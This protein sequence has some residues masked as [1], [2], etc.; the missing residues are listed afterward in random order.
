MPHQKCELTERLKALI[1][2]SSALNET[3]RADSGLTTISFQSV[4]IPR[5]HVWIDTDLAGRIAIDLEDWENDEKWDNSICNLTV[6]DIETCAAIALAWL[7]GT[8]ADECNLTAQ[9]SLTND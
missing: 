7:H 5:R 3:G 4:Q 1:L 8:S 6:K 2:R 9:G